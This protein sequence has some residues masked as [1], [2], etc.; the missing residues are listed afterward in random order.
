MFNY[1]LY[2][3]QKILSY[4]IKTTITPSPEQKGQHRNTNFRYKSF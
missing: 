2:I 3:F 1:G 4:A